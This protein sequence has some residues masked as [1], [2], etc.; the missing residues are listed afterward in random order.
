[1]NT[2]IDPRLIYS[3]HPLFLDY[4]SQR[5]SALRLF[6]RA[7]SDFEASAAARSRTPAPRQEIANVLRPYNERLGA[8]A[9]S[10][11]NIAALSD[12]STLCVIGGQ[13]AGFLG[14]PAYTL[15]KI[16]TVIHT[17]VKIEADLEV[18]VV[19]IFW[20]A[21][22][23]HDFTEVNRARFLDKDGSLRT[24]SFEWSERG[25]PIES[26]PITPELLNAADEALGLIPDETREVRDLFSPGADDD[27]STWHARIWSRLFADEGLVLVEPRIIRPLAGRFYG[28]AL[29]R[30]DEVAAAIRDGAEAVRASGYDPSLD[31]ERVGR[32]FHIDASGRRGRIDDPTPHVKAALATPDAYSTDVALR[33]I[34]ADALLPTVASVLGPSEI[35]YHAMLLPLYRLFETPQPVFVPRCGYTLLSGAEAEL[36]KRLD[37]SIEIALSA[38]FDPKASLSEA[39]SPQLRDAF[40]ETRQ[41]ADSVLCDLLPSLSDLDPGLKARWRQTSDHVGQAIDRLEERA[42]R[43]DLARRG[44]SSKGLHALI[45]SLRPTGKPQE[46]ALSFVHF[47]ARFGL[48]WIRHLPGPELPGR[49]AHYAVT[50]QGGE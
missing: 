27:Y 6:H 28:G 29:A 2:Q 40:A 45:T 36:L 19:P 26:L 32:V 41:K 3:G 18:R 25:L 12:R 39:S 13:Q 44:L 5:E 49:F 7:P 16:L 24:V 21:T 42:V 47:A 10:L 17:A 35:A 46:R 1:M 8:S 48:E 22:E 33:P 9:A 37:L 43:A 50:I 31:P 14:G 11:S 15:Y 4:V 23:D 20:L 34:L 30:S 38:E